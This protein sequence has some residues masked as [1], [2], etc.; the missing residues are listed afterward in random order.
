[1]Q[2]RA[3]ISGACRARRRFFNHM[4]LFRPYKPSREC[5]A[6]RFRDL[7]SESH[8]F[9]HVMYQRATRRRQ[10]RRKHREAAPTSSAHSH[11]TVGTHRYTS[12]HSSSTTHR[13]SGLPQ[14]LAPQ[15]SRAHILSPPSEA[16]AQPRQR[17]LSRSSGRSCTNG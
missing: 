17:L 14:Q 15:H 5:R 7:S 3:C 1:M 9:G 6:T 12:P 10:T 8:I 16:R 11:A 2:A 4:F 13:R